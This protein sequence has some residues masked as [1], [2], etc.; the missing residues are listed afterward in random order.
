MEQSESNN[1][2]KVIRDRSL[3]LLNREGTPESKKVE[4]S[5]N[6][7]SY[8]L[9]PPG[10]S[11]SGTNSLSD[12]FGSPQDLIF[13]IRSKASEEKRLRTRCIQVSGI[14]SIFRAS[15]NYESLKC[16]R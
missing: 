13:L 5:V 6:L 11:T 15:W 3:R 9:T 1:K 14:G 7:E 4:I 8:E 12:E 16:I 10:T 2:D